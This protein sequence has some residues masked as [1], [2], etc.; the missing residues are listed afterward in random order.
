MNLLDLRGLTVAR[1]VRTGLDIWFLVGIQADVTG[2]AEDDVPEDH[3]HELRIVADAIRS[4]ITDG[5]AAFSLA[6]ALVVDT[7]CGPLE[8]CVPLPE[9][10]WRPGRLAGPLKLQATPGQ[11]VVEQAPL[12]E[13]DRKETPGQ[14]APVSSGCVRSHYHL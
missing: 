6:G 10:S 7:H 13:P 3:L 4:R 1:S 9:P 8:F 11:R 2:L 14:C 12:S 5:L